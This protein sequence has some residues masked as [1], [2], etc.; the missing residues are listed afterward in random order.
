MSDD[1]DDDADDDADDDDADDD[2]GGD[3]DADDGGPAWHGG[4]VGSNCSCCIARTQKPNTP[5]PQGER[6]IQT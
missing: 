1:D 3:D 2:D 4:P 5:R 6:S